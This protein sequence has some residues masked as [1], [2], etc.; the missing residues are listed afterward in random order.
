MRLHFIAIG[1]AAMHSLAIALHKKGHTVTGSDDEIFE[2]SR[3]NLLKAGILPPAGGWFPE[4]ITFVLDAVILGMHAKKDNPELKKAMK[5][6]IRIYSFPEFLFHETR[7]K[8]RVV[9]AGSHGKTTIT[10]MVMH[11]LNHY[12]HRFDYMVGSRLEGFENMVR[13]EKDSKIAVFE[14]DEYLSS[15]LDPRPKLHVYKPQIALISGISWDHINVF[16]T[17]DSYVEQF[18]LFIDALPQNGYLVYCQEDTELKKLVESANPRILKLPY[19]AHPYKVEGGTTFLIH[20]KTK[21]EVLVFGRHN[22]QNISGARLI[23]NQLGITNDRFYDAIANF[24]GSAGRLELLGRNR[25]T[26]VFADFAHSPSKVEATIKAAR[27]Q[28]PGKKLIACLELH[29]YSSLNRNFLPHYLNTMAAADQAVVYYDPETVSHKKLELIST[30]EI[31]KAFGIGNLIVFTMRS[32][33]EDY[34]LS[35][36]W[37]GSCILFMS[38]GNFSGLDLK[39]LTSKILDENNS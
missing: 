8:L 33:L 37:S 3:S 7:D 13:L 10:G 30:D 26:S 29:T 21:T 31:A 38:S 12:G 25:S 22:M 14:G 20:E 36:Q 32:D 19:S 17:W 6:G 39:H 24:G 1:G 9:I 34:F 5:L 15:C 23:C 16:P 11:I 28:Y 18:R 4:R 27:D 2:P 35:R